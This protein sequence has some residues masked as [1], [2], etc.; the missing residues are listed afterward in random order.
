MG[1]RP[2]SPAICRML[3]PRLAMTWIVL[4]SIRRIILPPGHSTGFYDSCGCLYQFHSGILLL[5]DHVCSGEYKTRIESITILL[6]WLWP[7]T[8]QMGRGEI[9]VE[10]QVGALETRWLIYEPK[11]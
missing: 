2:N 8:F 5:A 9:V 11:N 1:L 3:L 7:R 10:E 6:R 4:R